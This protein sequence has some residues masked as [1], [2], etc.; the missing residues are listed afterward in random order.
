MYGIYQAYVEAL[1][2]DNQIKKDIY[3]EKLVD[4]CNCK[5]C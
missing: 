1:K 2:E 5:T 3:K 4:L